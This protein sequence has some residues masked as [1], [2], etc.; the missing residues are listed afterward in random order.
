[1]AP[2]LYYIQQFG[3]IANIVIRNRSDIVFIFSGG[4]VIHAT[5][6]H[7]GIFCGSVCIIIIIQKQNVLH[8]RTDFL[9]GPVI[10]LRVCLAG[11]EIFTGPN[12]GEQIPDT[13]PLK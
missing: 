13:Q 4:I 3:K 2:F 12:V 1:M 9:G 8:R 7:A 11:S 5:H 6:C 10:N